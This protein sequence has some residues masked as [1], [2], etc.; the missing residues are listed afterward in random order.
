MTDLEFLKDLFRDN[1]LHVGIGTITQLG[2]SVDKSILRAMVNLL[3]ENREIVC[4]VTFSDLSA[5]TFPQVNDLVI[6][7]FVDGHPD[8]AY[9]MKIVNTPDDPFP[10]FATLGHTVIGSR[11]G[12]KIYL[13]S[14][15]KISLARPGREPLSPIV[16]GDVLL[17][18][19]NNLEARIE[20][21][22]NAIEANPPISTAV[23]NPTTIVNLALALEAVRVNLVADKATYLTA[24]ST[25]IKS[26]IAFVE[27]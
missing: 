22:I 13:N 8:E 25:N 4:E 11:S 9:V 5:V 2:L 12:K 27:R 10:I 14:D 18:Y 7:N 21:I 24:P 23:G 15:T 16:L 1:R 19:L 20:S 17:T 3:P 26:Q 6:V